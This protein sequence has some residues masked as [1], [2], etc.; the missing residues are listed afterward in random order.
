MVSHDVDSPFVYA[1]LPVKTVLRR[2]AGDVVKRNSPKQAFQTWSTWNAVRHGDA[3]ADPHNTFDFIMRESE[4]RGLTSAFYFIPD[5]SAGAIDGRYTL[6][7]PEIVQLMQEIS[8]RGHEIGLHTSFNTYKDCDQTVREA[9]ILRDA[10]KRNGIVQEVFGGRQHFLRWSTPQT[11]RNWD[12]AGMQY[13][14]T[15]SFADLAGFRCGTCW[16][17]PVYDVEERR[18]LNLRERPLIVMEC[19]IIDERYMN[20]GTDEESFTQF[21]K[22]KDL[23]RAYNG[24][25]TLLWHNSRHVLPAERELYL[26]VLDA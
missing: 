19:S 12:A 11:F 5:H 7:D 17:Y 6:S 14:S 3:T 16:E 1:G 24:D 8:S 4:K 22:L 20:L 21:R 2:M 10:M 25:Y 18:K 26:A 9:D 15:L 13:D 23:C